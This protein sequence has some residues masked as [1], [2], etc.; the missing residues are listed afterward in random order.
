MVLDWVKKGWDTLTSWASDL[1]DAITYPFTASEETKKKD[2]YYLQ[3]TYKTQTTS[4][5]EFDDLSRYYDTSKLEDITHKLD[6]ETREKVIKTTEQI[7]GM[8]SNVVDY[9]YSYSYSYSIDWNRISNMINSAIDQAKGGITDVITGAISKVY[10][11]V[12]K[13]ITTAID[14][15]KEW[16]LGLIEPFIESIFKGVDL[17]LTEFEKG[18]GK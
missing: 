13:Q 12:S 10:N 6:K 5:A 8:M 11:F 17:E 1:W 9:H 16:V 14:G 2:T 4:L 18:K 3:Q 15:I 7:E